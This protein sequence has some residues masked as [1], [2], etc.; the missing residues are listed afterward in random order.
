MDRGAAVTLTAAVGGLIALQ[1]PINSQLGR[2]VG[3]FQ[4]AFVSFVLGTIL[5]LAIASVSRGGLGQIAEARSL[6][7]Q[8]LAGGILGALYV[9][10]V[11]VTVR[12]LGAGGVT[13]ATIAGQLTAS[14]AVDHFGAL[15]VEKSPVTLGKVVGIVLLAV[16][17]W[18]I[19]RE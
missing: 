1:A 8:Y 9:T 3:T 14:V 16:G 5:L 13:A 7:L 19:V 2:T 17:V 10:S 4:A 6:P 15:H 12:T 11:L 18:L